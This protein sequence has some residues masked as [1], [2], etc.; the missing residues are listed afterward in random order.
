M[1]LILNYSLEFTITN[2]ILT[3]SN[4]TQLLIKTN[5]DFLVGVLNNFWCRK[6]AIMFDVDVVAWRMNAWVHLCGTTTYVDREHDLKSRDQV[7]TRAYRN[8]NM[9]FTCTLMYG[10]CLVKFVSFERVLLFILHYTLLIEKTL[11]SLKST[12]T[13]RNKEMVKY[14]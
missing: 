11:K 9:N 13:R 4:L 6:I 5:F 8:I 12:K 7:I 3:G 10:N 14:F 2:E 1:K